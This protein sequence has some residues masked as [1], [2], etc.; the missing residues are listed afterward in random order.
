MSSM[1]T[2][3][4]DKFFFCSVVLALKASMLPLS[5]VHTA[6]SCHLPLAVALRKANRAW[7]KAGG[8]GDLFVR[9]EHPVFDVPATCDGSQGGRAIQPAIQAGAPM[10]RKRAASE[11]LVRP[12]VSPKQGI[13]FGLQLSLRR[14]ALLESKGPYAA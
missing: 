11:A 14:Q 7:A 6:S 4:S 12:T 10:A 3:S 5:Y 13:H 8:D 2:S 9:K 1:S